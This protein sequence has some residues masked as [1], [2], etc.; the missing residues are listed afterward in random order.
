ME[1]LAG[2]NVVS[3]PLLKLK[4]LD[5]LRKGDFDQLKELAYGPHFQPRDDPNVREVINGMLNY[6]VQVSPMALVKEILIQWVEH[7]GNGTG[8]HLDIN[9]QDQNGNTPLH[10]A[11]YQSRGDVV[12]FLM[13]QVTINDCIVNDQHLQP[14][15]A[16]KNLNIAQMM[17]FKR[18][19]YVAEIAQEFRMAFNN[20]DFG[21]LETIL[22][23]PRNSELLDING[24]DP[25]TG[26]TVLHEFVKK[27]DVIMCRWLLEH[28]ADPFKRDLKGILPIEILSNVNDS[29]KATNTK[30]AIDIEL[31]K[32]LSESAKE[33]SVIDV[34]TSL[35]EPPMFKGYLRK[36]TNF[37]QGYRLRWFILSSDGRLS[38]YKDQADTKNACR[39]ALNMST[40][41]L[42]LDSSEKLKFEIISGTGD[43]V[44]WHLKGNHPVET[45]KWVW[46]I[47]GAIRFAKDRELAMARGNLMSP[48]PI[49]PSESGLKSFEFI[50]DQKQ[51]PNTHKGTPSRA[52]SIMS[53]ED[54]LGLPGKM[55]RNPSIKISKDID[56]VSQSNSNKVT[57]ILAHSTNDDD[58]AMKLKEN[59]DTLQVKNSSL[60]QENN[61]YDTSDEE[62]YD[63]I[64][65]NMERDDDDIQ[66]QYGP[67]SQDLSMF[68]RTIAMELGTLTELLR[69]KRSESDDWETVDKSL[70]TVSD[71]FGNLSDLTSKRDGR[72]LS[73]LSKQRDVNNIWIQSVKDLELELIE[74]SERLANLEKERKHV[75]KV[76]QTKL[77]E[78]SDLSLNEI[79]APEESMEKD[80]E[81]SRALEEVAKYINAISDEADTSDGDEFY[82]AEDLVEASE[83]FSEAEA[84]AEEEE[85]AEE[86]NEEEGGEILEESDV[87]SIIS[88]NTVVAVKDK[89]TS[90]I[91]EE[92][93]ENSVIIDDEIIKSSRYESMNPI[94]NIQIE[95]ELRL[96]KEGSFLGYEDGIR[97][98]LGL[99]ADDRPSISLWSVLKSMV[100]KDISKISLPVSFNEPSSMLQRVTEDLEYSELLDQ[101]ATFEDSTLRLLYV[102]VFSLT[103][104]SSTI[105]RVAKPF[106]PL[107][108]ET[109]EYT[110]PDKNYRFLSEQ[111]SHHPVISAFCSESPKWDFWGSLRVESNFNGRTFAFRQLDHWHLKIRPDATEEEDLYTWKKPENTLVGILVGSPEIDSHG[112]V[113]ITNHTTGDY[114]VLHYKARGWRSS[115]AYEVRGEV[116]N[117]DN[118]K[119]WVLGGHWNDSCFAKKV[120]SNSTEE[121][122]LERSKTVTNSNPNIITSNSIFNST[123][124]KFDGSKFLVWKVT[125]RPEGPFNLTSFA[126]TLNA[127]QPQLMPWLS[128]TDTRWRPDQ[129]AMEDGEYDLAAEEKHRLE[130]KQR[131][132]RKEREEAGIKY[133]PK[134]FT[135]EYD[136]FTQ[137]MHWK[138]KGGYWADRKEKNFQGA[139]DIF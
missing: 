85:E 18:S 115:G 70:A 106:N 74:K 139:Y 119:Q 83:I 71:C 77:V 45:N 52:Y 50:N 57:E 1:E 53:N 13:D 82:D 46:A 114:C 61:S 55:S 101:A 125:K 136:P 78:V 113:T 15:E 49:N 27:R 138:F 28:S 110:R 30:V 19:N 63:D 100:G 80:E 4:L 24:T 117:K 21:H 103:P 95:T 43:E 48:M 127:P 26:D 62:N 2:S 11:C 3:K 94:T 68:Q 86:E 104:Y 54:K 9:Y 134:W 56:E 108:G 32:L 51:N 42:H 105:R 76:L 112:D 35:F 124:P 34:T 65:L 64:G 107:L 36:W 23:N 79:R 29:D 8:M 132:V 73:M 60:V 38:Y 90:N 130:V 129:R 131:A 66:V 58:K 99:D 33:Q 123:V 81:S 102:A 40:C 20:R 92:T 120:T 137:G 67:Y 16:C 41:S 10:L 44:R 135:Q 25:Q 122:T 22:S 97:K 116:Y 69:D 37:A 5:S 72:L 84:E 14:I 75:K 7:A 31:K 12:S 88:A 109:F 6:A 17:Q 91:I 121:L 126:V 93:V 111:V 59:I 89:K 98:K 87:G 39:G 96:L 128:P 47:Q 118:E 133:E